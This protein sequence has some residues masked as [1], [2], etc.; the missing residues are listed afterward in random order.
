MG[1]K[2]DLTKNE[3]VEYYINGKLFKSAPYAKWDNLDSKIKK[4]LNK[5]G[6]VEVWNDSFLNTVEGKVYVNVA[7]H[8]CIVVSHKINTSL[9][10]KCGVPLYQDDIIEGVMGRRSAIHMHYNKETYY[11][12]FPWG[13]GWD[14][15][16]YTD[17]SDWTKVEDAI[18]IPK[19]YWK[20]PLMIGEKDI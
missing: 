13:R 11:V 14:D 15:Y 5:K 7:N 9:V 4:L 3:T 12:R 20:K 1:K 17:F 2:I 10:D 16:D 6:Y 19:K 8:R 18:G